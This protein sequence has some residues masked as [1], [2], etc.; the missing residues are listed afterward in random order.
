MVT[1]CRVH[2]PVCPGG[3]LGSATTEAGSLRMMSRAFVG[4]RYCPNSQATRLQASSGSASHAGS[5]RWYCP[6]PHR[7]FTARRRVHDGSRNPMV[8]VVATGGEPS[9]YRAAE[10]AHSLR[11]RHAGLHATQCKRIWHCSSARLY[12]DLELIGRKCVL[13]SVD[14]NCTFCRGQLFAAVSRLTGG[15]QLF[16]PPTKACAWPHPPLF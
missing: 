3:Q 2:V 4:I 9:C 1:H 16:F 15:Q 12:S 6:D 7:V 14:V 5:L 8:L 11:G 13:P 10:R